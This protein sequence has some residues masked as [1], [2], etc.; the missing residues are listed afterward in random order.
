LR[1]HAIPFT[2]EIVIRKP[3]ADDNGGAQ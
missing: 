1:L 2:G 3:K